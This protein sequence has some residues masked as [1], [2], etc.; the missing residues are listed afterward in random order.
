[1]SK[2]QIQN[3]VLAV[4]Y[5]F[6]LEVGERV[7][8]LEELLYSGPALSAWIGA[9]QWEMARTPEVTLADAALYLDRGTLRKEK[10][11]CEGAGVDLAGI[12]AA[13]DTAELEAG[14]QAV[15]GKREENLRAAK[16]SEV[17]ELLLAA[18]SSKDTD[19]KE[20]YL[21]QIQW[22]L[23]RRNW[24]RELDAE[25]L[26]ALAVAE[27]QQPVADE[28]TVLRLDAIARGDW[29]L[30][31]N[32]HLG[33]RAGLERGK[34]LIVGGG[35][36]A[37]KTSLG[38]VLAVDAL[39][40]NCPVLFLQLELSAMETVEHMQR[41]NPEHGLEGGLWWQ[42]D[43]LEEGRPVPEN[44]RTLLRIP[45]DPRRD[46]EWIEDEI[47]SF[48]TKAKHARESDGS[49]HRVN[50]L[51]IIDYVQLM[52]VPVKEKGQQAHEAMMN[53][54][55][56]IVKTA[57]VHEAVVVFLSQLNKADQKEATAGGTALA[58]ADLARCA[59]AVVMVQKAKKGESRWEAC[60]PHEHAEVV[61]G[62]EGEARL[63]SF[64]KT[65]GRARSAEGVVWADRQLLLSTGWW[66]SLRDGSRWVEVGEAVAAQQGVQERRRARRGP[67][68]AEEMAN[69]E[70]EL[71]K[72][73]PGSLIP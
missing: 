33:R 53:W 39:R 14:Y 67:R 71:L 73:G 59:D 29:A 34:A 17:E 8:A 31:F 46:A 24:E 30:W 43:A 37:G 23:T 15:L 6:R 54:V 55:S 56:R 2:E 48:A 36:G 7:R 63:L 58:G 4:R 47:R 64:S 72:M 9:I 66:A 51:V 65:R 20:E 32:A 3:E 44:W 70:D 21:R 35:P 69:F 10:Q 49:R 50:G 61:G 41:Q 60:A 25:Q 5:V 57:S 68:T 42:W 11:A 19:D 26:W 62:G 27:R 52:S 28:R 13:C 1:M 16:L 18:K 45:P 38:C 40:A 12:S 22:A